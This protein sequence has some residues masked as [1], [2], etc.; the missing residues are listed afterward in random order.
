MIVRIRTAAAVCAVAALPLL[1]TGCRPTL[2]DSEGLERQLE[3]QLE[4]ELGTGALT[5]TCPTDVEV[6]AKAAFECTASDGEGIDLTISVTQT[7]DEGDVTWKV[8]DSS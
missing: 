5:V 4:Q 2:L 6:A 1:A 7:N 3:T 8:T